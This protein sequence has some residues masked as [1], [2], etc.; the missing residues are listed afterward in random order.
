MLENGFAQIGKGV[1]EQGNSSIRAKWLHRAQHHEAE[2]EVLDVKVIIIFIHICT[3]S[4]GVGKG[5]QEG[6]VPCPQSAE[7]RK[8]VCFKS[9]QSRFALAVLESAGDLCAQPGT[10]DIGIRSLGVKEATNEVR[11]WALARSHVSS[12]SPL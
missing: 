12:K 5:E 10:P 4:Q 9:T 8:Q 6:Q 7:Q 11:L 3:G 2:E 1:F